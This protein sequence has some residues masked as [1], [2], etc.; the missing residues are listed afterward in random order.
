LKPPFAA[1]KELLDQLGQ[2]WGLWVLRVQRYG[3][4][5]VALSLGLG[6]RLGE[7]LASAAGNKSFLLAAAG[8]AGVRR[9]LKYPT[10][11]VESNPLPAAWA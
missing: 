7:R 11:Y 5:T 3:R 10:V 2:R 8:A 9:V 1:A 4:S 6:R